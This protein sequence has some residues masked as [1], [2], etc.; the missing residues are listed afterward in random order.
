MNK[1]RKTR[2]SCV[3]SVAVGLSAAELGL[4]SRSEFDAWFFAVVAEAARVV[5][6]AF[7]NDREL[8]GE[9]K[10]AAASHVATAMQ[11]ERA[12]VQADTPRPS[13]GAA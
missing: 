5:T 11:I 12:T 13:R 7:P 4:W 6:R 2:I 1:T 8:E 3:A 10:L 9:L